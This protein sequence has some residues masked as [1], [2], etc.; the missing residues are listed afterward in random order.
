MFIAIKNFKDGKHSAWVYY[1]I[2]Q[3]YPGKDPLRVKELV[4][5]GFIV[6]KAQSLDA[7]ANN[8]HLEAQKK[9]AEAEA[10]KKR[11]DALKVAANP[12]QEKPKV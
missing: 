8:L 9:V 11:A 5:E 7:Q 12:P 4:H 10:M 1:K 3:D 2:G 6:D